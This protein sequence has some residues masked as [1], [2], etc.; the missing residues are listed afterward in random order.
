MVES[1]SSV[2]MV[3]HGE[4]KLGAIEVSN[5]ADQWPGKSSVHMWVGFRLGQ[6]EGLK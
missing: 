3:K 6:A 2:E 1:G 4:A 5:S